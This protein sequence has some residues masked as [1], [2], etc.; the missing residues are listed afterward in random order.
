MKR[1]V[2]EYGYICVV[3]IDG[4]YPLISNLDYNRKVSIWVF[5]IIY[6]K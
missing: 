6:S 2:F 4:N 5:T 1:G 3:M